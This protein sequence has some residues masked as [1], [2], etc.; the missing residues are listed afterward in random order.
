MNAIQKQYILAKAM[1]DQA[2]AAARSEMKPYDYLLD[3]GTDEDI[4]K[5]VDLEMAADRKYDVNRLRD[6]LTETENATMDWAKQ[7]MLRLYPA[8]RKMIAETFDAVQ[9]RH[10]Q[11]R[12]E[13][14]D[15]SLRLA[16]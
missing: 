2:N 3:S 6:A 14:V 12:E 15:M 9:T 16:A 1:F 7:T 13:L 5:L 8:R 4:E 11:F 10:P